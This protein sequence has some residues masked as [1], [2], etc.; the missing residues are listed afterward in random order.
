MHQAFVDKRMES[1]FLSNQ[2][3]PTLKKI[4]KPQ[5]FK[6]ATGNTWWKP[7]RL[8]KPVCG[9][10]WHTTLYKKGLSWNPLHDRNSSLPDKNT[11]PTYTLSTTQHVWK[12][13]LMHL[14]WPTNQP[15]EKNKNNL[16]KPSTDLH[17]HRRWIFNTIRKWWRKPRF[18]IRNSKNRN[19]TKPTIN[20]G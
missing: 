17:R 9:H 14:W 8:F 15:T 2:K 7:H 6:N 11:P 16:Q 12:N 13:A 3:L 20:N 19:K 1:K 18:T 4:A 10:S 5:L